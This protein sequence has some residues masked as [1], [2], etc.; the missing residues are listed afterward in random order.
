MCRLTLTYMLKYLKLKVIDLFFPE[1]RKVI[2][3]IKSQFGKRCGNKM[4]KSTVEKS[5]IIRVSYGDEC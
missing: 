4:I 1:R 5:Y 2:N 3:A